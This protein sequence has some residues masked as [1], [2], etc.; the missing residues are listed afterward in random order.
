MC[1]YSQ[2]LDSK[3]IV[4]TRNVQ[5]GKKSHKK[6]MNPFDQQPKWFEFTYLFNKNLLSTYFMPTMCEYWDHKDP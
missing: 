5:T 4:I 3:Y 6:V 2:L 1:I